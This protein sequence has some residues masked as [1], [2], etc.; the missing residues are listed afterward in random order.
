M[1]P[2]FLAS[3][4]NQYIAYRTHA[5][6]P[7]QPTVVF[8]GGFHSDMT[9]SKAVFLQQ[10][11]LKQHL[12]FL[13]FDYF[14]HGQSSGEFSMGSIGQWLDDSLLVID[15][16]TEGPVVLVGSSMGGW[17]ALLA[18]RQRPDRVVGVIGIAAALNFTEELMWAQMTAEQQ[19][20]IVSQGY[21]M[22]PSA[23]DEQ[24]YPITWKLIEEARAHQLSFP[25]T[26][27]FPIHLLQGMQDQDVPWQHAIRIIDQWQ[28]A[29]AQLT[30]IKDGDHRLSRE[31]DLTALKTAVEQMLKCINGSI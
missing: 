27:N 5:G 16:L 17:L 1:T 26:F 12:H 19:T 13:C 28:G 30:L 31:S 18:A 9:G 20:T 7:H 11:C 22:R 3:H 14:G 8:L 21:L 25:L 4:H 29:Q 6:H 2:S 24:G 10:Y 15:R 23:Y